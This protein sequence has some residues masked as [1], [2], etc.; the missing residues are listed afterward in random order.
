MDDNH[1][2][3]GIASDRTRPSMSQW[4]ILD[5]ALFEW[6]QRH[7]DTGFPIANPLLRIK[8]IKIQV[9]EEN[10]P[11]STSSTSP[12]LGWVAYLVSKM[13]SFDIIHSTAKLHPSQRQYMKIWKP[14]G[15]STIIV[16]RRLCKIWTKL[17]L[18]TSYAKWLSMDAKPGRSD[19]R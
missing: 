12:I 17:G 1:L 8:A 6:H 11:I 14:L 19:A 18:L 9:L 10:T 3:T 16:R 4:T 2:D 5:Q 13:S 7:R 15:L